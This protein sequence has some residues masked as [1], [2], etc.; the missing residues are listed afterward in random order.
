MHA[1]AQVMY[2]PHMLQIISHDRI[3]SINSIIEPSQFTL[4]IPVPCTL[5]FQDILIMNSVTFRSFINKKID[6]YNLITNIEGWG[7]NY[8]QYFD[9]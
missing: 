7:Y 4:F 5:I 2:L 1:L 6:H 9:L 3:F 8:N